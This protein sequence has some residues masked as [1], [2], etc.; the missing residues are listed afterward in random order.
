MDGFR[1]E[2]PKHTNTKV[3]HEAETKTN[4]L[5]KMTNDENGHIE[6]VNG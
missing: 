6:H 5:K 3:L 1:F 4:E 2:K